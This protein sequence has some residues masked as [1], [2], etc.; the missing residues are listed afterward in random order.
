MLFQRIILTYRNVSAVMIY[1]LNKAGYGKCGAK[2]KNEKN[3]PDPV[4]AYCV[5]T[6]KDKLSFLTDC[7]YYVLSAH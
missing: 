5:N 3:G 4:S 2:V 7:P 1:A 6:E